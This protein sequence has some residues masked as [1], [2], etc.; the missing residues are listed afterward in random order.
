MRDDFCVFILTH[1]RANNMI[2]M[3]TLKKCGYT[4]KCY[5]VIDNED[6]QEAE[7]KKI[8][9]DKVIVFDKLAESKK[10]DTMDTQK[11]RNTIVYAR[12]ACFSIARQVGVRYFCELDDD[13]KAFH[14]RWVEGGKLK[15]K[16]VED[17]DAVFSAYLEFLISSHADTVALAQG[18]D[19]IGGANGMNVKKRVLRK[20]MNSFICDV[21]NPFTFIGRINEDVNTYTRLG[22]VGKLFLTATDCSLVQV[23]T[24]AGSGGMTG[25]YLDSGTYVKSFYTVMAMPSCVKIGTMG[26]SHKRMHHSIDW[27]HCVPKIINERWKKKE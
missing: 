21:E 15:Y 13:Y 4:G 24:Q 17:M 7:Y 5:I 16:V 3:D 25:V 20:A 11:N 8:Y 14:F 19:F 9:G 18:G 23:Q 12:N 2:T 10:F 6:D 22:S 1:G 27:Q 26:S